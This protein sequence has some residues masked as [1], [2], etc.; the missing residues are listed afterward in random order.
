MSARFGAT[1]FV[2]GWAVSIVAMDLYGHHILKGEFVNVLSVSV[3]TSLGFSLIIAG[4][5]FGPKW[6]RLIFTFLPLRLFGLVGYSAYLWHLPAI[7]VASRISIFTALSPQLRFPLIFVQ[8][9]VVTLALASFFY[10][11]VEKPFLLASR[12]N[13][14]DNSAGGVVV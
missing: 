7:F 10:L 5:L 3:W 14:G 11:T 13:G 8:S 6:T 12:K 4:L 9:A 2:T 1:Y